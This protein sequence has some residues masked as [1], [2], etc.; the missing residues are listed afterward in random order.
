MSFNLLDILSYGIKPCCV[1]FYYNSY[2]RIKKS[3]P[4]YNKKM[5]I[6]LCPNCVVNVVYNFLSLREVISE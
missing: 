3:I 5:D 6:I 4:E 2:P 1:E